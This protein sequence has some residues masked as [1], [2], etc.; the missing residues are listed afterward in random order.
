LSFSALDLHG[1]LPIDIGSLLPNSRGSSA[2]TLMERH[3]FDTDMGLPRFGGQAPTFLAATAGRS[4]W[5]A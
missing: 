2:V 3:E 5:Y 4:D 1:A